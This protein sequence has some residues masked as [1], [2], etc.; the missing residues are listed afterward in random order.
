MPSKPPPSS[1][2]TRDHPTAPNQDLLQLRWRTTLADYVSAI[3]WAPDGTYLAASSTAG[4]VMLYDST[5]GTPT[6]L[7]SCPN[8]AIST[9]AFSA[10]GQYLAAAGQGGRLL[11]WQLD[12]NTPTPI[13][14]EAWGR[15]WIEQIAWHPHQPQLALGLGRTVQLWD[16]QIPEILATFPFDSSSILTLAWHPSGE[17]LSAG[18]NQAVKTWHSPAWEDDPQVRET[19]SA[20]GAIAWSPDG[21]YLAAGNHDRTLLIW[22]ENNPYPWR[23]QGF[24]GKVRQLSW[25]YCQGQSTLPVLASTS[26]EGMVIW[27]KD[28]DPEGKWD[29]RVFDLHQG[30]ITAIAFQPQGQLLASAAED[31]WVCL[32]REAAQAAQILPGA[33]HGFST[34]A[35]HPQGQGLAA[36][37]FWGEIVTWGAIT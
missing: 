31:G 24:P 7:H 2:P 11:V 12:G 23:M 15:H 30:D 16:V 17:Y 36:G 34:L 1:R 5:T 4:E 9:L 35:W 28:S 13:I 18:G 26:A 8:Q 27:L 22:A 6:Q 3:A 19:G 33:P 29:A 37:G 10:D 21:Q 14:Q 32:W 25:G 20:S